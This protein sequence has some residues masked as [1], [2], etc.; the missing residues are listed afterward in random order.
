MVKF[1]C[2]GGTGR[3]RAEVTL[4]ISLGVLR[5]QSSPMCKCVAHT[6]AASTAFSSVTAQD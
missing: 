6:G 1:M 5:G 3:H 2:P 4:S